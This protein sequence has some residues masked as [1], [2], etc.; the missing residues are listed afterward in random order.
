M[1]EER[2][3]VCLDTTPRE[4]LR[5]EFREGVARLLQVGAQG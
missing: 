3:L 5:P 2:A 1:H 4:E